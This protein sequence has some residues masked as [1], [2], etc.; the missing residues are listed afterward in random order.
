MFCENCGSQMEE[1]SRFCGNCG[2]N[3]AV[4][5]APPPTL[6]PTYTQQAYISPPKK[7][8][9]ILILV[10]IIGLVIIA[11][12][13]IFNN[14]TTT[15]TTTTTKA[16]VNP[17]IKNTQNSKPVAPLAGTTWVCENSM[18]VP[19]EYFDV[20]KSYKLV[21]KEKEFTLSSE[22]GSRALGWITDEASADGTYEISGNTFVLTFSE[23]QLPEDKLHGTFTDNQILM[24]GL[25]FSKTQ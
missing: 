24:D 22:E 18:D 21:F 20:Y 25:K 3:V 16:Q 7:I 14:G 2:A 12:Y 5:S 15:Q 17:G 1:N 8:N 13:L 23:D 11:S 6:S 10:I 9:T 19:D 4:G